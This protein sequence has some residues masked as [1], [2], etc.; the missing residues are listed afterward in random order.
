VVKFARSTATGLLT[1]KGCIEDDNHHPDTCL[2]LA[3]GLT[4]ARQVSVSPDG[5]SVYVAGTLDNDVSFFARSVAGALSFKYCVDD[6]GSPAETCKKAVYGLRGAHAVVVSPDGKSV[7]AAGQDD[8][9]LVTFRRSL[10]GDLTGRGCVRDDD[11]GTDP[12]A[13]IAH[14]YGR[15]HEIAVSQDGISVYVAAGDDDAVARLIRQP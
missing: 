5:K 11:L 1:P 14:G 3:P 7:Y 6:I 2:Q 12:C 13:Q 10:T 15:A 9:A 8:H 4:G